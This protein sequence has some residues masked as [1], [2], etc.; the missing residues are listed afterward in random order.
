MTKM[1]FYTKENCSYNPTQMDPEYFFIS[2]N[3][4]YN[5]S[6]GLASPGGFTD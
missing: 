2:R 3:T 4:V 1:D 6:M 5:I